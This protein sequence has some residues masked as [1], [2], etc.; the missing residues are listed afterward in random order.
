MVIDRRAQDL[1]R[2][3]TAGICTRC[4]GTVTRFFFVL[5]KDRK[6]RNRFYKFDGQVCGEVLQENQ[7]AAAQLS[8]NLQ[9]TSAIH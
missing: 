1:G 2:A 7:D 6:R 8:Y 5:R 4:A 9:Q 3:V